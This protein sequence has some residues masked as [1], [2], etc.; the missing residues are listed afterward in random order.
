MSEFKQ[1]DRVRVVK[2]VPFDCV[3]VGD[4]GEVTRYFQDIR[5]YPLWVDEVNGSWS[6]VFRADE[7]ELVTDES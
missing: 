2:D 4:I 3:R 7:L 1:G 5:T 6:T